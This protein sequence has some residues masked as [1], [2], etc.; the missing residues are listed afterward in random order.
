ME[1][2]FVYDDPKQQLFKE[3]V[4]RGTRL[5]NIRGL[6]QSGESG[7]CSASRS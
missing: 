1:N 3:E 7:D 2:Y 6:S 5:L 4:A